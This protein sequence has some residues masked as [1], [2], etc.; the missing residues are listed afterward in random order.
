MFDDV[1]V[2]CIRGINA[3]LQHSTACLLQRLEVAQARSEELMAVTRENT[4]SACSEV[5]ET[6]ILLD[7]IQQERKWRLRQ[8]PFRM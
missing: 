7:A 2:Y 8:S 3:A 6:H 4:A 1:S 5:A